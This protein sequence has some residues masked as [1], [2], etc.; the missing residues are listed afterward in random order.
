MTVG[1]FNLGEPDDY[2]VPD[3]ALD[4]PGPDLLWN[5]TAALILE[6]VSPGGETWEKLPFYA[7]HRV[8]ELVIA[9]LQRRSV[10][11]LS[12]EEG[13]YTPVEQSALVELGPAELA[14]QLDWP[15]LD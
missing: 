15:Q 1:E 8:D 2:R 13:E 14:D 3:G 12:L 11:W 7:A 6:V 4:R 5:P 9:D 10:H